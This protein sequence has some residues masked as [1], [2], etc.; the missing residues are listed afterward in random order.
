MVNILEVKA[1]NHGLL[2]TQ[3]FATD[4]TLVWC[5]C[6]GLWFHIRR[7]KLNLNMKTLKPIDFLNVEVCSVHIQYWPDTNR[8]STIGVSSR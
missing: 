6:L 5:R 2:R 7:Q 8:R 3:M 4:K 1:K